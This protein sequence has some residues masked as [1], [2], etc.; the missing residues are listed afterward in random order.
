MKKYVL[1]SFTVKMIKVHNSYQIYTNDW[2]NYI[3]WNK[4]S[5]LSFN[6][7]LDMFFL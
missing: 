4:V 3:R 6:K 5:G 1:E 7:T 2:K